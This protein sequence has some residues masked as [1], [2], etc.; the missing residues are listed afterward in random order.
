M[1]IDRSA[2]NATSNKINDALMRL[3]EALGRKSMR[4]GSE[5]IASRCRSIL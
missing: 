4:H 5:R 3:I 2:H 1:P